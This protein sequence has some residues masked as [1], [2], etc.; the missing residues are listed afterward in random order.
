[1]EYSIDNPGMARRCEF[2]Q[3]HRPIAPRHAPQAWNRQIGRRV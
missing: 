3:R 1:V 2:G